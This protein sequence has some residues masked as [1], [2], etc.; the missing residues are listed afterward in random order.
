LCFLTC[1]APPAANHPEPDHQRRHANEQHPEGA[2]AEKHEQIADVRNVEDDA[3]LRRL[4]EREPPR[5]WGLVGVALRP[6]DAQ[7]VRAPADPPDAMGHA[8][9][10]G[11]ARRRGVGDRVAYLQ[12]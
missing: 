1:V 11:E 9:L 3:V 6:E 10:A 4:G 2:Q 12:L 8:L 7:A 5:I